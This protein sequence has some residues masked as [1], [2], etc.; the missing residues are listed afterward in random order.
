MV[1]CPPEILRRPLAQTIARVWGQVAAVDL[2]KR[3]F[4]RSSTG[5]FWAASIGVTGQTVAR[6]EQVLALGSQVV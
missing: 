4:D 5:P 2:A 1:Q 3:G 6:F